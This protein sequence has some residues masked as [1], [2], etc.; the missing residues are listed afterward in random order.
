MD[1]PEKIPP[2]LTVRPVFD[3]G[4]TMVESAMA[5]CVG[6]VVGVFLC[7]T[8]VLLLLNIVGL[9]S[10]I[11][12]GTL[13]STFFVLGLALSPA[14]YF[15]Q[16]KKVYR[17][18]IYNFHADHLDYQDFKFLLQ[19]R[20]GRVRLRDIRDVYER[21]SPLQARRVLT[22]V[23]LLI[24]GFPSQMQRGMPGMKI[25]DVPENG[26]LREKIVDLVE[27]SIR[28]YHQQPAPP[29]AAE[30]AAPPAPPAA[31]EG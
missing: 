25:P 16:K 6:A 20:R 30:P 23:Y 3:P 7:G 13:F 12:G 31:Q 10:F 9:G 17:R 21:A 11:S 26:A 4:L 15:E 8:F 2:L 14:L 19:R 24:P 22:S 29:P 1:K 5:A 28:R 27:D 18:T